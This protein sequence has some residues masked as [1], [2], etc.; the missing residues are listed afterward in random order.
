MLSATPWD[1]GG[2]PSFRPLDGGVGGGGVD[3]LQNKFFRLFGPQFNLK[4]RGGLGPTPGSTT[5]CSGLYVFRQLIWRQTQLMFASYEMYAVNYFVSLGI[6][7]CQGSMMQDTEV[8]K[9]AV[10]TLH[11]QELCYYYLIVKS[12]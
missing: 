1:K 10:C 4:I 8:T 5:E 3:G 12:N 11:L 2:P 9:S 7:M 6:F